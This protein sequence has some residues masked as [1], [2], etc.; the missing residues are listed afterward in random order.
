[1]QTYA[2]SVALFREDYVLLIQR[3]HKPAQGLWT[4]PGGRLEPGETSEQA[5]RRELTEE[6][7]FTADRLLPVRRIS[8]GEVGGLTL[9]VFV[10]TD[11]SGAPAF[12]DE[13]ANH[14]WVKRA[15]LRGLQTTEGLASI[16]DDAV[17][18]LAQG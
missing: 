8:V 6:T 14:R 18:V 12:S 10:A 2:A 7:G 5:A 1:M 4:L 9:D 3:A 11:F 15:D 13:V 17:A 16:L